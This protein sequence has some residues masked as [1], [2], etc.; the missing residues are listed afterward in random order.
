MLIQFAKTYLCK[1]GIS[2]FFSIKKK[3]RNTLN[4]EADM[5][6]AISNKVQRIEKE[7]GA[8]KQLN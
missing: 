5:Q 2:T 7:T 3:S 8:K 1:S 4:A 6:I